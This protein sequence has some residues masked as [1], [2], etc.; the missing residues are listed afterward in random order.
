MLQW[1][2][3]RTRASFK[4]LHATVIYDEASS[5]SIISGTTNL[6]QAGLH[7]LPIDADLPPAELAAELK[8]YDKISE[9]QYESLQLEAR[10][11]LKIFDRKRIG[12]QIGQLT[13]GD[14]AADPKLLKRGRE[15]FT[16]VFGGKA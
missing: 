5:L 8:K 7:Y 15:E 4:N 2:A 10:N 16:R 3:S 11:L 12:R 9:A 13:E 14:F 6:F 1:N